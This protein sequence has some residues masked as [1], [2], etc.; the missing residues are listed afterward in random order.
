[1]LSTPSLRNFHAVARRLIHDG[2]I[3]YGSGAYLRL[4]LSFHWPNCVRRPQPAQ[5]VAA[6]EQ[7]CKRKKTCLCFHV[8]LSVNF[9]ALK[10]EDFE[11]AYLGLD[12]AARAYHD[13]HLARYTVGVRRSCRAFFGCHEPALSAGLG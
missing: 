5:T 8:S 11:M 4:A 2:S 13:L 9:S 10:R 1:V 3:F 12:D 6:G 7:Y